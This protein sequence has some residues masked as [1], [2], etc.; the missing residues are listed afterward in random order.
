MPHRQAVV[1]HPVA[2]VLIITCLAFRGVIELIQHRTFQ[3]LLI[4]DRDLRRPGIPGGPAIGQFSIHGLGVLHPPLN[5]GHPLKRFLRKG[6]GCKVHVLGF[7]QFQDALLL[8]GLR[9]IL[10]GAKNQEC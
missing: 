7:G 1:L 2:F 3:R 5:I 8:N 10:E 6:L 4:G 9:Q